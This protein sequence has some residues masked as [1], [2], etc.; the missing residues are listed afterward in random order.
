MQLI[1]L[2]TS[3]EIWSNDTD[4]MH[5]QFTSGLHQKQLRE[6]RAGFQGRLRRGAGPRA[7]RN[8]FIKVRVALLRGV[9][10]A[11]SM[12]VEDTQASTLEQIC[13]HTCRVRC[14]Q[15][16]P[17]L[18]L[19]VL[20]L[21]VNASR[22]QAEIQPCF[23][24]S[25]APRSA[26]CWWHLAVRPEKEKKKKL[27]RHPT[28]LI[29]MCTEGV[30]RQFLGQCIDVNRLMVECIKFVFLSCVKLNRKWCWWPCS[31]KS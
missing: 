22:G 15:F 27:K 14:L 13:F 10:V 12:I 3:G 31:V 11:I 8:A 23:R 30:S 28:W 21:S 4:E 25:P 6:L 16:L 24:A 1:C 2:M 17:A 20:L 26:V 9:A 29:H 7:S 18:S 19:F 5:R